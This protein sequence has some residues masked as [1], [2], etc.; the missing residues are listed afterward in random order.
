M[1]VAFKL[2]A[3]FLGVLVI[4]SGVQGYLRFLGETEALDRDIARDHKLLARALASAAAQLWEE[5]DEATARRFIAHAR[6]TGKQ[7]AIRLA[8][9]SR[10]RRTPTK[11]EHRRATTK[12]GRRYLTEAPVVLSDG[13]TVAVLQLSESLSGQRDFLRSSLVRTGVTAG[14]T[15]LLYALLAGALGALLIG[16][17]VQRLVKKTREIEQGDL[18]PSLDERGDDELAQLAREMNQLCRRL[19]EA[20]VRVLSESEARAAAEARAR[21]EEL[22]KRVAVDRL[23]HAD[24]LATIGQ[25]ASSVAHELGTPLNVVSGRARMI[26][27]DRVAPADVPRNLEIII[28][29]AEKITDEIRRLLDYSRRDTGAAGPV[30]LCRDL[31]GW[32]ALLE[33]LATRQRVDVAF[34]ARAGTL[35]VNADASRLQQVVVN[36]V[37][38][39]IQ[40]MPDGGRLTV[41]LDAAGDK[42]RISVADEGVGMSEETRAQLFEPFFTTKAAG[43]GTGLGLSVAR[44]IVEESGGV[45]EVESELGVGSTFCVSLPIRQATEAQA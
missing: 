43:D 10:A 44:E 36:L 24:R 5:E 17:P 25:L 13:G 20:N 7:V 3:G 34:E 9:P 37:V 21:A 27:R 33:P 35:I 18:A 8:E 30:D 16:R 11:V 42:A 45:I 12:L 41:S 14:L 2:A 23:H 6:P 32:L 4:V 19:D 39:G 22:A 15:A 1:R 38:N 26:L 31:P 40:A 28:E 29:Q